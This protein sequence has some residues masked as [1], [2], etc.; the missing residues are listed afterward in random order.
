MALIFEAISLAVSL[1]TMVLMLYSYRQHSF[2]ILRPRC[3]GLPME[4]LPDVERGLSTPRKTY[5]Y[6]TPPDTP[7]L[8]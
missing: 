5:A 4:Q 6:S 2:P 3:L 1:M 7:E 8:E